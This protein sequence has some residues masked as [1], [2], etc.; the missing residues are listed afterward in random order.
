MLVKHVS[1]DVWDTLLKSNS[2][3]KPLRNKLIKDVF[4]Q[5]IEDEIIEANKAKLDIMI[6]STTFQPNYAFII[7]CIL[8]EYMKKISRFTF[9]LKVK[10]FRYRNELLV[11]KYPPD[12]IYG[13]YEIL[14]FLKDSPLTIGVISN[15]SVIEG[16]HL[17]RFLAHLFPQTFSIM[18]FSDEAGL[19]KPNPTL[20]IDTCRTIK[21]PES[22]MIHIG[23]N[24]ICDGGSG[25]V[26]SLIIEKNKIY[27]YKEQIYEM[28]NL[29]HA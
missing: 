8:G 10:E 18:M 27:N 3:Y 1:F 20:F 22:S 5:F 11:L 12:P 6:E 4:G 7:A 14:G 25:I 24:P 17:R 26:K 2:E 13:A 21:V 29:Q 16:S 23:D 19:A 28:C 9:N 15:T